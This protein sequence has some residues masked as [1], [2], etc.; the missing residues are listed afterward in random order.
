LKIFLAQQV[1]YLGN[2]S[3]EGKEK[4]AASAF[5][6]GFDD[7]D[8]HYICLDAHDHI[9]YRYQLLRQIGAG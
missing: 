8:G 1:Y 9:A 2:L 6:Y 5:N 3:R 7:K 4:L